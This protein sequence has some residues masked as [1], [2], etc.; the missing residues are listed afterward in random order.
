MAVPT[1]ALGFP[2]WLDIEGINIG[3]G[4]WLPAAQA[5]NVATWP[6]AENAQTADV[7]PASTVIDINHF[8]P[9]A[10]QA[11]IICRHNLSATATVRWTRGTTLGGAEVADSGAVSAWRF[12]PRSTGAGALYD[13]QVVMQASSSAQ[14]DRIAITDTAN[15][16]SYVSIGRVMICPLIAP[17]YAASYGLRDGH[18]EASTVAKGKSGAAWPDEQDRLRTTS[19]ALPALT[20]AEGDALHEMEQVEGTTR[21]VAYLPYGDDPARRQRYGFTGLLRELSGLEYPHWRRRSRAFQIDQ[22][23]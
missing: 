13:V 10:A 9:R 17:E 5:A 7:A 1:F 16:S 19:F 6:L 22:R 21:E 23:G 2:N 4:E 11:L 18:T 8:V 15:P 20:L 3:G 14:Y 12:T